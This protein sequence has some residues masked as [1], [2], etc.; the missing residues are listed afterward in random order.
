MSISIDGEYRVDSIISESAEKKQQEFLLRKYG[1]RD[2][3]L[4]DDEIDRD[5]M[6]NCID[7]FEKDT[8][9]DFTLLI[10][11]LDYMQLG[12]VEDMGANEV[13]PN[14]FEVE[15]QQLGEQFSDKLLEKEDNARIDNVIDFITLDGQNL[16]MLMGSSCDILPIW[17]REKRDNCFTAK[18][19]VMHGSKCIFSPIAMNRLLLSWRSG[20]LD[21]YLP[22]EIGLPE[23]KS[24]LKGW[25][26]R[27][28]DEMVKDISRLFINA[29]FCFSV[30]EVELS[31]RFPKAGFPVD[32][33]DYDV[34]AICRQRKEIWLIESK[35]LQKVGSVY[36]DQMQQKSFFYQHKYDEKFQRRI[37]YFHANKDKTLAQFGFIESGYEIKPYMVTNKLFTSRYK[38]VAFPIITFYEFKDLL[39]NS[40]IL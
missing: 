16:K 4:M 6:Q 8:G 7:T 22:Y 9:V 23:V 20:M 18:P 39:E 26:K 15:R 1:T 31:K 17:E 37:D 28:E 30:S 38:E 33:G 5:F 36:E 11:L 29:D 27:Y 25:K 2:Y 24:I 40:K 3:G 19:I 32:L 34:I 35:V 21:W 13:Y 14:V 10:S 12:I